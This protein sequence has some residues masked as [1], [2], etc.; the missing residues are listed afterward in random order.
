MR[1]KA[2]IKESVYFKKSREERQCLDFYLKEMDVQPV[3][4]DYMPEVDAFTRN[5]LYIVTN[6]PCRRRLS[7]EEIYTMQQIVILYLKY[8]AAQ[9]FDQYIKKTFSVNIDPKVAQ[10]NASIMEKFK[11]DIQDLMGKL[12]L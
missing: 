9:T 10:Y 12:D 11:S 3:P 8:T 7:F 1:V 5:Y 6:T 4:W 2:V